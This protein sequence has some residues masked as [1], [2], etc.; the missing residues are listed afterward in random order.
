MI[1]EMKKLNLAA[2]SYDRENVLNAL[3]RTGAA[4]VK[5]HTPVESV[6]SLPF[7]GEELRAR[8][9]ASEAALSA[10]V[11]EA[12]NYRKDHKIKSEPLKDGFEVSYTEFMA[13]GGLAERMSALTEEVN[14]L[15]DEKNS[16]KNE[17]LRA[18]RAADAARPF[19]ALHIPFSAFRSTRFTESVFGYLPAS[20]AA[21]L[22]KAELPEFVALTAAE[23]GE[24]TLVCVTAHKSCAGEAQ[25]LLQ[26]FSFTP[27]PYTDGRTGKQ[28]YEEA[29]GEIKRLDE[30]LEMIG[31]AFSELSGNVRDFKIYCDYLAFGLEKEE[32]SEKIL[33]T[34]R[35][36]LLEAYV[37]AE[38]TEAVRAELSA[39]ADA[40]YCEF[41]D[42]P[43]DET[44]PTLY[45]NNAV[46]TNFEAITDMYSPPNAREFDPNAI[47]AFFYSLF[48]GF[49]MADVGYG[50]L[51][52]FG[53]GFLYFKMR[54]GTMMKRLCGVFAVGGIFTVIWGFLFNS[55]LGFALLPFKVMPD[56]TGDG[57]SWSL[58][59]IK[60]P[61]LLVISMIIGVVQ[62]MAGYVCRAVQCWRRGKI[63]DGVFDGL[64]W[65]LF[66]LGVELAIVGFVEDFNLS[67][68]GMVGGIIAGA[69]LLVAVLTAGRKEK[70]L[71]KFTKGFGAAYGVINYASDILSY[72]RLYGLMLAGAVIADI[73]SSNSVALIASGNAAF[74]ILGVVIM[75]VGHVFNLAIGL[76]GAYIHDAR[77]QYVEFY[78]RF[79]E[80]E[81]EL[82]VPLG[83][84]HKHVWLAPDSSEKTAV[85]PQK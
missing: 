33:A 13:A 83:S 45:K 59:G 22:V 10:L 62:L 77:L 74:I 3:Q 34:E 1:A 43:Q 41:S 20:Q 85:S 73:I 81:G 16:V 23:A 37:P 27:C 30:E 52:F 68:L 9:L 61:A 36:F 75:V 60:V 54:K 57:M 48:L 51:M 38:K 49:I 69:S 50:L 67:V 8:L 58:A 84:E 42:V 17:L 64:I 28:L 24:I 65:A 46:V 56:L 66:S 29:L 71:G 55:F 12:E 47:M 2:M 11:A 70:L 78:G 4:E 82:F 14:R 21:A 15:L 44:P 6:S 39:S 80:G 40:I 26:N 25:K 32:L 79:Y 18:K 31:S 35:T 19:S 72:A 53:G 76:L 7:A 63:L 5:C